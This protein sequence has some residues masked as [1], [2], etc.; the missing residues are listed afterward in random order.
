MILQKKNYHT[1]KALCNTQTYMTKYIINFNHLYITIYIL[2]LS[3]N[4][5]MDNIVFLWAV[6]SVIWY[7]YV[8]LEEGL[9][10]KFSL[11]CNSCSS[12][13]MRRC[14]SNMII[15]HQNRTM[16]RMLIPYPSWWCRKTSNLLNLK[17]RLLVKVALNSYDIPLLC[18]IKLIYQGVW[19][20]ARV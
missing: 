12:H 7:L 19:M 10:W 11:M 5:T 17:F 15:S 18:S 1:C 16:I 8:T 9:F 2:S 4:Y 14:D 13:M 20:M 6:V 3:A